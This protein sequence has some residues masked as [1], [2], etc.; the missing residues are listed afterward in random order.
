MVSN[1]LIFFYFLLTANHHNCAFLHRST[2]VFPVLLCLCQRLLQ[3]SRLGLALSA[4]YCTLE[5][6]SAHICL[7]SQLTVLTKLHLSMFN[8]GSGMIEENQQLWSSNWSGAS[9]NLT[10]SWLVLSFLSSVITYPCRSRKAVRLVD[11]RYLCLQEANETLKH[12][13][14]CTTSH[15]F[16]RWEWKER[17]GRSLGPQ[18]SSSF[19]SSQRPACSEG[20]VYCLS[21]L[22]KTD[23]ACG[24]KTWAK[25]KG[26]SGGE[27]SNFA[28]NLLSTCGLQL[29]KPGFFGAT[30]LCHARVQLRTAVHCTLE[31]KQCQ[32][33]KITCLKAVWQ[34]GTFTVHPSSPCATSFRAHTHISKIFTLLSL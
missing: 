29:G 5:Q 32:L 7:H 34:E 1:A 28:S 11:F 14:T 18:T 30:L 3:N 12:F 21:P 26:H 31:N 6:A 2:K 23:T 9:R 33:T 16:C 10:S 15:A 19:S 25:P 4:T 20:N 17:Q 27:N 13:S 8:N 24:G 22:Q